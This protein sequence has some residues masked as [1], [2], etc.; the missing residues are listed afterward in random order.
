M[1][2]SPRRAALRGCAR[3]IAARAIQGACKVVPVAGG[4]GTWCR[5]ERGA[6]REPKANTEQAR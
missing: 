4:L 2:A 6:V 3:H 5:Q 1:S